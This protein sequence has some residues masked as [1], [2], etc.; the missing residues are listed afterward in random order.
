[1]VMAIVSELGKVR[2]VCLSRFYLNRAIEALEAGN[3]IQA[4]CLLR[5][6]IHR[7]L[8]AL[9]QYHKI[10]IRKRRDRTPSIMLRAL[11]KA[12]QFD[13]GGYS[14]V[15]ES[16]EVGNKLAHCKPVK[17]SL[18]ESCISLMHCL[19]DYS[20]EIIFPTREGGAV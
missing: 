6:A 1:M 20:P 13:E 12:K 2:P 10:E 15:R 3:T 8:D 18:V 17:A 9:C 5:E 16:I 14:W 19:M 11:W 7:Y 4:G